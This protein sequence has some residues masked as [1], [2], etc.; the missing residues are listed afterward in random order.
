MTSTTSSSVTL[1]SQSNGELNPKPDSLSSQGK[2]D[3]ISLCS[4]ADKDLGVP[5]LEGWPLGSTVFAYVE[6]TLL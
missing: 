4:E 5:V 2:D 6:E 3:Q 1:C